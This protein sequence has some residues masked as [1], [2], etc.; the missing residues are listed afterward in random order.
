M[1]RHAEKCLWN[2]WKCW[3]TAQLL[4]V[5]CSFWQ[6]QTCWRKKSSEP[7]LIWAGKSLND[8]SCLNLRT[9]CQAYANLLAGDV[10]CCPCSSLARFSISLALL[11]QLLPAGVSWNGFFGWQHRCMWLEMSQVSL[12]AAYIYGKRY[13]GPREWM[14]YAF[15][16]S[17][18]W[19]CLSSLPDSHCS[20][21][22]LRHHRWYPG[23]GQPP[24]RES[25][26]AFLFSLGFY[27]TGICLMFQTRSA[28][29]SQII[30]T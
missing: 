26:S 21:W 27:L 19:E 11:L 15:N 14:K 12:M 16:C 6:E 8:T 22:P 25:G 24:V 4:M 29:H 1:F 2:V 28:N 9:W 13:V 5:T 18:L 30:Q 10:L 23:T 20:R 3:A 7:S 17:R